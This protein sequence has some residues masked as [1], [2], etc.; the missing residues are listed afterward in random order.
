MTVLQT[1]AAVGVKD[2]TARRAKHLESFGA[3]AGIVIEGAFAIRFEPHS[4]PMLKP[5]TSVFAS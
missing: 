3:A 5:I 1:M 2:V 4:V